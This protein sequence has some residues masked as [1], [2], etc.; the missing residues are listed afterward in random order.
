VHLEDDYRDDIRTGIEGCVGVFKVRQ[1]GRNGD[2]CCIA[3]VELL[4]VR[5]EGWIDH[6]SLG[7]AAFKR[8]LLSH[9]WNIKT[10]FMHQL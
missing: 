5:Y 9:T 2:L 10:T 8:V 7:T 4:Y 6:S 3:Y 1:G